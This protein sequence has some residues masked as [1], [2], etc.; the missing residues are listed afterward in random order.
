[1]NGEQSSR[2][3]LVLL[4]WLSAL[5]ALCV[6]VAQAQ[7]TPKNWSSEKDENGEIALNLQD[8]D[9]RVFINT[10][11]EIMGK[12]FIIDPRVTGKVSFISGTPLNQDEIHDV[13]LSI[14]NVYNFAAVEAGSVIKIVPNNVIK[15]SPTRVI[16]PNG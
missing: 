1:M 2:R 5:L 4:V 12:N 8:V 16:I 14:L 7:N 11:A 13:F 9:I 15:Q 6:G 3:P 10:V